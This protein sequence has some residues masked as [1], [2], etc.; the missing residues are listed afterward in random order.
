MKLEFND[1]QYVLSNLDYEMI[2]II[3]NGLKCERSKIAEKISYLT[4]C[5]FKDYSEIQKDEFLLQIEFFKTKN[6]NL[7]DIVNEC[8]LVLDKTFL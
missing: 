1:N 2:Q 8:N 7:Y 3:L 5:L 6:Q 4:T